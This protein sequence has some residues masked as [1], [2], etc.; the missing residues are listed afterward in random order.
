MGLFGDFFITIVMAVALFVWIYFV[1]SW[2]A[3]GE[4]TFTT[5]LVTIFASILLMA[6]GISTAN[7]TVMY[8]VLLVLVAAMF[9]LPLYNLM[10]GSA[11]DRELN[12]TRFERAHEAFAANP[13]NI[14]SRFEIAKQLAQ[15]G[16]YGHAIAIAKGA[17]TLLTDDQGTHQ[18]GTRG[19][20]V[21]ELYELKSWN[22]IAKP[23]DF[24]NVHCPS[25]KRANPPGTIACL[26]CNSPFLLDIVRSGSKTAHV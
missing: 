15:L 5:G 12:L 14:S 1:S 9:S 26:S 24:R 4:I 20:F 22:E 25:C 13:A 8:A 6:V 3:E 23:E 18:R 17:E 21:K 16:Q 11:S 2:M 7:T 10:A 19:M